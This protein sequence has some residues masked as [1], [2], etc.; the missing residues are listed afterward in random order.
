MSQ[1]KL[2]PAVETALAFLP[3]VS[4]EHAAYGAWQSA[5]LLRAELMDLTA[6][7]AESRMQVLTDRAELDAYRNAY[8]PLKRA[9]LRRSA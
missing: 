9:H 1:V 5:R 3:R 8:G 4:H 6:Q 7:L 2:R